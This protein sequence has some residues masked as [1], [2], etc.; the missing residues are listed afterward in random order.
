MIAEY[1]VEKPRSKVTEKIGAYGYAVDQKKYLCIC[2]KM[3]V[4]GLKF[5]LK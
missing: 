1:Q 4:D 2:S 5:Q 3:I